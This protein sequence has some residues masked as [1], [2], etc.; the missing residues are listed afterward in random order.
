ML[1]ER[2]HRRDVGCRILFAFSR[3][4]AL[5]M[6]LCLTTLA[7]GQ[8]SD[9]VVSPVNNADRILLQ[10][11]HP[12]WAN[13]EN[14]IG[15]VPAD[16]QLES[17]TL[18]LSRP[19]QEEQA[20]EQFLKDQLNPASPDFHHWLT[21]VEIGQRYGVS[22][23]DIESMKGWLE[24]Q[25][26][27]FDSVSNSLVRI[28]FSGT[29]SAVGNAFGSEMHYYMVNGEKRISISGEAQIPAALAD[30]V[31]SVTGLY[32]VNPR[33]MSGAS[34]GLMSQ[35]KI[36]VDSAGSPS[37]ALASTCSGSPC[38]FIAPADFAVIYDVNSVYQN[39][40]HGEGQTI[41]IIGRS[42]VNP[43]DITNFQMRAA[44]PQVAPTVIVPPNGI[45]PPAPATTTVANPS[46]DQL[47][48]TLDVTRAGSIAYGATIDL[49]I[50]ANTMTGSGLDIASEYAVDTT[51]VP[52]QVMNISFGACEAQ[53]G[54]PGVQFWDN[55]FQQAAGEG[56]SVFV[57]SGDGGVAG[58][59]TYFATP[60]ATQIASP[61]YIC[62]SSYDTCVGGTEF[63]DA[64]NL[65]LYWRATDT[66]GL[67]SALSYIPEGAWNEPTTST[68][69]FQAAATGGGVSSIIATPS[70]QT[71]LGVPSPGVGRYTPDVAFSSSGHDG[72]FA[73]FAAGGSSCVG[74]TSFSFEF[75]YGTS[76]AGP[77]MAG[78]A[79]LLNQ[80]QGKAQGNLNPTLYKLAATPSFNVFHDITAATSG[81][82][83][84]VVTTPSMCN[85]STPGPSSLT[86]GLSGFLVGPGYDE[87]TGLGSIN[88][89]NLLASWSSSTVTNPVPTIT[90]INPSIGLLGN[91]IATLTITGTN[92][93]SGA[94]VSFN[95][96]SNAG[97]VSNGGATI[98]AS[99]PAG[100]VTAAGLV[101]V[102]VVNPASGGG[103]SNSVNF[104]VNNPVPALTSISPTTAPTGAAVAVTATGTGFGTGASLVFN[105][106]SYAGTVT[107]GGT[108]LTATV[109][110]SSLAAVGTAVITVSNPTPGGGTS[111]SLSFAI[112][113]FS[114]T[115]PTQPVTVTAGQT[116]M[117]AMN[118]A[119][120]G[121]TLP[122]AVSFSASNLPP[123]TTATFTPASLPVGS[124]SGATTLSLT[125][126]AHSAVPPARRYFP[127][128]RPLTMIWLSALALCFLIADRIGR[129][130][131]RQLRYRGAAALLLF[132]VVLIAGCA[133][134]SSGT[135]STTPNPA[136]GTSAGTYTITIT[137]TA[138]AATRSTTVTLTVQ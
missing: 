54:S 21:P 134:G 132:C 39:G 75:F 52:A 128:I 96:T 27:H 116:A 113:N 32:T 30:V 72:Y 101:P 51:P 129:N 38:D 56:I 15:A 81:V 87:A 65:S 2:F 6:A 43:A 82:S 28:H 124:A 12:V 42:A 118:F 117:F 26:L 23:S 76:A 3:M 89:A 92:F 88:V 121:G 4:C 50:S 77:D 63:A 35:A 131:R 59:D 9:L 102:V 29:A 126:T 53:A 18:V 106:V 112:D 91:A 24:S 17:L 40:I 130:G 105:G 1:R 108:T 45:A 10:G 7:H 100:E 97:T 99:I 136:T 46:G 83:N 111:N 135:T 79:A 123:L 137:A 70:W 138:G 36:T 114:I 69:Q 5:V 119:T 16:L 73:C 80:S 61:N 14:D 67:E 98:T 104:T 85:N 55:L 57:V 11:H 74:T 31:Q 115:G 41:A 86:G 78:I 127:A 19:A 47:E 20:L 13:D 84:C 66:T 125:T 44:L 122:V 62:S 110:S 103:A 64:A 60:P 94:T 90:S 58:C 22:A 25:N 33:P 95:G 109:A 107:N 37:P 48:A 8:A 68:G 133:S 49:I 34:A 71:G 120:Q 93:I